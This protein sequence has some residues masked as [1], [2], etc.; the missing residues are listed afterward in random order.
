MFGQ[1]PLI[2][3]LGYAI[4]APEGAPTNGTSLAFR[5]L[6]RQLLVG[7]DGVISFCLS[8][9][10]SQISVLAKN[11]QDESDDRNDQHRKQDHGLQCLICNHHTTPFAFLCR[12][13][14]GR[15]PSAAVVSL[16]GP[17]DQTY[18]SILGSIMQVKAESSGFSA[19]RLE[20]SVPLDSK[21]N[22]GI[23]NIEKGAAD[24]R[25]APRLVAKK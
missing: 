18:L 10:K 4:I 13:K 5:K 3:G 11:R 16:P 23:M 24:R 7:L 19:S 14:A 21:A 1:L 2:F 9:K 6:L 22:C 15:L 17:Y 25:L 8:A 20:L 12:G